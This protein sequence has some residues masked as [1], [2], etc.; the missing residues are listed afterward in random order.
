MASKCNMG[1]G[2]DGAGEPEVVVAAATLGTF[3]AGTG[4]V[5]HWTLPMLASNKPEREKT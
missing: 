3:D 5:Q 1:G 4:H 2:T